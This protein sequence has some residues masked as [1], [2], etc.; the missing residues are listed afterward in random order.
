MHTHF[1]K[2]RKKPEVESIDTTPEKEPKTRKFE[3]TPNRGFQFEFI[4]DLDKS[5]DRHKKIQKENQEKVL[6]MRKKKEEEKLKKSVEIPQIEED[7]ENIPVDEFLSKDL[8]E[9]NQ[10]EEIRPDFCSNISLQKTET[11][12]LIELVEKVSNFEIDKYTSKNS[13]ELFQT[14]SKKILNKFMKDVKD[15]LKEEDKQK[16]LPNEINQYLKVKQITQE[17]MLKK[18]K[19]EEEH[20]EKVEK[21]VKTSKLVENDLI[22]KFELDNIEHDFSLQDKVQDALDQIPMKIDSI[23]VFTNEI[24]S[25]HSKAEKFG[26]TTFNNFSKSSKKFDPKA[27]I[28]ALQEVDE[29]EEEE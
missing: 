22:E 19:A 26:K 10:K 16:I 21:G 6:Q 17:K 13:D 29:S 9:D 4:S 14:A 18:L 28:E 7:I 25:L 2:K 3:T 5:L 1:N 20:W 12:R 27:A 24:R 15:F 8:V 23:A 11:E